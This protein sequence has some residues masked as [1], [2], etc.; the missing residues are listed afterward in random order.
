MRMNACRSALDAGIPLAI[1]SDAPVTPL[2]PLFTAWCAVNRLSATGRILGAEQ[3]LTVSEAL[4]AITLGAAWTLKMDHEIGSIETGKFADFAI[5]AD[6]P[7]TVDKVA[8]K[9]VNVCGTVVGGEV[10]E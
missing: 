5:L 2:A 1:H 8:L 3:A 4:H 9:D 6:D 10:F 7:F